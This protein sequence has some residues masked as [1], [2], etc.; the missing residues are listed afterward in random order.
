M[1]RPEIEGRGFTPDA[2][3]TARLASLSGTLAGRALTGRGEISH[4]NGTYDLRQVRI[5]NG[6]SHV[7]IDGRWGATVDL[8]WSADVRSLALLHPDLA[9]ELVST[10]R[11]NGRA[12]SPQVEGELRARRVGFAGATIAK[13]DVE[14]DVDGTDQRESRLDARAAEIDLGVFVLDSAR[15]DAHGRTAEHAVAF[16]FASHGN[17]ER[18]L[19]G[20]HGRVGVAGAYEAEQRTWRGRLEESSVKFPDG[21]ATLLQ[22]ALIEASPMVVK[23][24]PICLKSDE[25]RLCV[26]GERRSSP[27]AWRVIYSAQ[28]WPLRRLLRSILGWREF[29]G[30]L[31]AAGWISQERDQ[32]WIGGMTLLDEIDDAPVYIGDQTRG[33]GQVRTLQDQIALETRARSLNP[34]FYEG[35]LRHGAILCRCQTEERLTIVHV[36]SPSQTGV[37]TPTLQHSC[38][39]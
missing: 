20:F 21:G 10:G 38:A 3:W 39:R 13:L 18:Q 31:Q 17:Q 32:D 8:R 30:R 15:L 29:D 6:A 5:A 36:L 19:P 37:T 22:P 9:G 14:V 25:A 24:A 35:L 4:R 26:E 27:A 33:G 34:K 23:V 1:R 7:D 2:P 11:V 28:D 16:E 12:A